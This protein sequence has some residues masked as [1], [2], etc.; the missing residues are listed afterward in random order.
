[1]YTYDVISESIRNPQQLAAEISRRAA[2][3]WELV[4][5]T[6]ADSWYHA[7]IRHQGV[8]SVEPRLGVKVEASTA[9]SASTPTS[10]TYATTTPAA[11]STGATPAVPADWYKDPSGRFEL[12]YWNG[13]AWTEHVSTGGTQSTDAPR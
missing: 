8:V 7:F 1:M 4:Q 13:T 12:R 6:T 2:D 3:G 11:A 10:A 5:I 9:S